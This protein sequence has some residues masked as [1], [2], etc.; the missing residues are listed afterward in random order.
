MKKI[1]CL[2]ISFIISLSVI[3][4]KNEEAINLYIVDGAPTLAVSKII[5]DGKINNKKV[6]IKIVSSTD[7]L[8]S[9]IIN[10]S[11]DVAVMPVNLAQK[12]YNKQAKIKLLS[13]NIFGCLH[14]VSKS[15]VNSFEDFIGEEVNLVGKMGTPDLSFKYLLS[16][17]NV[18]FSEEREENKVLIKYVVNDT[19]IQSL[20]NG[21]MKYALIG[22]PLVSKAIE[23]VEGLEARIDITEEWNKI[24]NGKTYTQ[25]GVVVSDSLIDKDKD[26]VEDLYTALSENNSFISENIENLGSIFPSNSALHNMS[27]NSN[28]ISRCNLGCKRAKN[29][30]SDLEFYLTVM[31]ENYNGG[32]IYKG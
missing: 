6:N 18:E 13:V 27:F 31:G 10:G 1:F 25:A 17:N 29:I 23:K 3:S 2:I 22:E 21:S 20:K 8:S 4:C 16:K 7:A 30:E 12:L 19:V 32:F 11:A 14:V 26:F 24:T 15:E 5:N 9:A 28:N